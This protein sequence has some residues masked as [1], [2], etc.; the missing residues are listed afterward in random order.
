MGRKDADGDGTLSADELRGLL[1]HLDRT[2]ELPESVDYSQNIT[3]QEDVTIPRPPV[4]IYTNTN[5]LLETAE[6]ESEQQIDDQ[7]I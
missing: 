3:D 7:K 6:S 5:I 4:N 1:K 2:T